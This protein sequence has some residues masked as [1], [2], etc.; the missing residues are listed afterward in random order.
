[1]S[2]D[3]LLPECFSKM[4]STMKVPILNAVIQC[5]IFSV[6]IFLIKFEPLENFITLGVLIQYTTTNATCLS[7]R[8]TNDQRGANEGFSL[9]WKMYFCSLVV[10]MMISLDIIEWY[11]TFSAAALMY[12]YLIDKLR[13]IEQSSNKPV[14]TFKVPFAPYTQTLGMIFNCVLAGGIGLLE[15]SYFAVWIL[16]GL[17]VYFS[18]SY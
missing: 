4:H 11:W 16:M 14:Y 17:I 3:G 13:R 15:W 18:Y 10:G 6:L 1:M 7:A 5:I 9:V 8:Y 2:D 12:I